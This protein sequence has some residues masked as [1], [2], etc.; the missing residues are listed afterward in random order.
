MQ[1]YYVHRTGALN[2]GLFDKHT[3][4]ANENHAFCFIVF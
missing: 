4:F 2:I 1:F 3:L